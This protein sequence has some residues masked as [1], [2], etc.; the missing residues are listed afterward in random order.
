MSR[1]DVHLAYRKLQ[2]TGY[3]VVHAE[4]TLAINTDRGVWSRSPSWSILELR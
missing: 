1:L 4:L 3:I 2:T